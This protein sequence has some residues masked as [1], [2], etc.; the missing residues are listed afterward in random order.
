M[1][2]I[3]RDIKAALASQANA[4][5]AAQARAYMKSAMPF[6]GVAAPQ[7]KKICRIV[8]QEYPLSSQA[9]WHEVMLDLWRRAEFREERYAAENL[10][11]VKA[12]RTYQTPGTIPVYREMIVDG[13]WWDL[14]DGIVNRLGE[15]LLDHPGATTSKIYSWSRV[16]D[17]WQRRASIICQLKL[18]QNTNEGLLFDVIETNM[19]DDE[20][21]IRKGIGWALR[22]YAKTNSKAVIRFVTRNKDSLSPLSKREGLRILL[23]NGVITSIP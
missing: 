17:F 8:F 5:K 4:E 11:A 12:Y 13:A 6:H 3:T 10:A 21:F 16:P 20:F 7:V 15:L 18:K 9:S 14:V 1:Q 23:K 22:E 19:G 2:P